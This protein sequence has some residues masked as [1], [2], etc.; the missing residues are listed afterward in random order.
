[1]GHTLGFKFYRAS[2][3]AD[4]QFVKSNLSN[5]KF[6]LYRNFDNSQMKDI[7]IYLF[8]QRLLS[9]NEIYEACGDTMGCFGC[10][11]NRPCD[12]TCL[13]SS[14]RDCDGLVAFRGSTDRTQVAFTLVGK[15]SEESR[16]VAVGI[17]TDNQMVSFQM[18][19][20]FEA[21]QE[22]KLRVPVNC[23]CNFI[24]GKRW[25]G[26]VRLRSWKN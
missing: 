3:Y 18:D 5:V 6:K 16:Y 1:M 15:I 13:Q 11:G 14:R 21:H 7:I 20:S 2:V 23:S 12:S 9:V 10:K 19:A 25:C 24:S 17:S 26:G 22:S 4:G 8:P